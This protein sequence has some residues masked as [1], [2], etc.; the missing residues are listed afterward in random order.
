MLAPLFEQ[1]FDDLHQRVSDRRLR[2][3]L[4]LYGVCLIGSIVLATLGLLYLVDRGL[5]WRA[6]LWLG[7]ALAAGLNL[8]W[9][10]RRQD[11]LFGENT[12]LALLLIVLISDL[13][14]GLHHAGGYWFA[15][16]PAAAFFLKGSKQGG[17]LTLA[18]LA[19]LALLAVLQALGGID[20]NLSSHHLL[21][22]ALSLA[23]V[24]AI[25]AMSQALAARAE[26]QLLQRSRELSEEILKRHS[27]EILLQ[28]S[29]EK[30]RFMA[31]RDPLTGLPNRALGFDRLGQALNFAGRHR[32]QACVILLDLQDFKGLNRLHGHEFGDQVLCEVAGRLAGALRSDCDTLARSG[33]DEFMIVL[34]DMEQPSAIGS[35][36][37]RLLDTLAEP[38]PIGDRQIE[39]SACLG[40]ACYP[41]DADRAEELLDTAYS[42][43]YAAVARSRNGRLPL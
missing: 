7:V 18:L 21:L 1:L 14:D 17:L 33:I 36:C 16:F 37:S 6:L 11:V 25:I 2:H 41:E 12:V 3:L 13:F 20:T 27:V 40:T 28:R 23:A 39:L 43:L 32:R 8:V 9:L 10:H 5:H 29:E 30:M 15:L 22:L 19:F 35:L 4:L 31:H 42:R 24:T 26:A 34:T 38:L